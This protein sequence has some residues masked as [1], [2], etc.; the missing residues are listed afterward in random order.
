MNL[1]RR[2]RISIAAGCVIVGTLMLLL[3]PA[4]VA[5]DLPERVNTQFYDGTN[6]IHS[7]FTR[8]GIPVHLRMYKATNGV[9]WVLCAANPYSGPIATDIYVYKSPAGKDH[10][11]FVALYMAKA[12]HM[13]EN[14]GELADGGLWIR[15]GGDRAAFFKE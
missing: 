14:R 11:R 15:V 7:A 1:S 2:M 4:A 9:R 6:Q 12:F 8:L 10:F 3:R 13:D 5:R